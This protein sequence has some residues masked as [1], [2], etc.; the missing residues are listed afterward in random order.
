VVERALQ[1]VKIAVLSAC[2]DR[3]LFESALRVGVIAFTRVRA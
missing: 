3:L 2:E 1:N